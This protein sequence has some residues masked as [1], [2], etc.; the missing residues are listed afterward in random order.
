[1]ISNGCHWLDHFVYL[2]EFS[3]VESMQIDQGASNTINTCVTLRN[4]A[5][6]TMVLTDKGS[7]RIGMQDYVE[8]R[9]GE[10]TAKIIN[11]ARYLSEDRIRVVRRARINKLVPY[12]LM[13]RT[14]AKKIGQGENGD[15]IESVRVSTKLVLDLEDRLNQVG[16]A[17]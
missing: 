13:Y 12:K 4:G 5:Y 16:A 1:L 7:E 17:V 6:F 9:S 10:A 14:I 15:S 8:L 2:N 11:N 3:A